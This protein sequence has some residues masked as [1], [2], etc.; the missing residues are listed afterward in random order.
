VHTFRGDFDGQEPGGLFQAS[1]GNLYGPASG[2]TGFGLI[3]R[4]DTLLCEDTLRYV[5]VDQGSLNLGFTLH[6]WAPGTWSVWAFY[7]GGF[8]QLWSFP[9]QAIVPPAYHIGI[10]LPGMSAVGPLGIL[11]VLDTPTLGSRCLDWKVIDTGSPSLTR[12]R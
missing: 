2:G 1:D 9:L 12:S 11:T 10:G 3:F 6:S 7:T 5:S 8:V 4:I